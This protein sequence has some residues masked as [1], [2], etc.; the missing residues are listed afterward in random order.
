LALQDRDAGKCGDVRLRSMQFVIP[1]WKRGLKV[2]LAGLARSNPSA[3]YAE[4]ASNAKTWVVKLDPNVEA[5][6]A[7]DSRM[8]P[9][10]PW[11][12][13]GSIEVADVGG[14]DSGQGQ[15]RVDLANDGFHFEKLLS[16]RV[17]VPLE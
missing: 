4:N 12:P 10:I 16:V 1:T 14:Y 3:G 5:E 13:T 2:D 6:L 11:H 17:C 8:H 7:P 9:E 15:I